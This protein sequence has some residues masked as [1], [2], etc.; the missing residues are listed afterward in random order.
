MKIIIPQ[1]TVFSAMLPKQEY[2]NNGHYRLMQYVVEL[3]YRS[4]TLLFNTLTRELLAL[5]P[6]ESDELRSNSDNALLSTLVEKYFYVSPEFNENQLYQQISIIT[7]SLNNSNVFTHFTVMPTMS[8][9]AR[10]FYCFEHGSKR[11][12]MSDQ[13]SKDVAEFI[14]RRSQG[15]KF[16]ILWFGGEPLYNIKAIDIICDELNKKNLDYTS[17]MISNGYLFDEAVAKRAKNDWKLS[18]VQITLDGTEDIYNKT[19]AYIYKSDKSPFEIVL[20]NIG[21]I[22]KNGIRVLIRL[23]MDSHNKDDLHCLIDLLSKRFGDYKAMISVYVW[24]LYDNR[25]AVKNIKSDME[26][27]ELTEA[28]LGLENSILKAGLSVKSLPDKELKANMC[29]ADGNNCVTV[30]PNGKI[31]KCDHYS[32]SEFIGDIYSN[33]YD[34]KTISRWKERRPEIAICKTCPIRP[35]CIKLSNCPELGSFDCDI[36]EQN[37]LITKLCNQ[38]RN[39]FDKCILQ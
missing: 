37:R 24:L 14:E 11:Y 12:P 22:V 4:N 17:A 9:N 21:T 7:Q 28:L 18:Y 35:Q 34:E 31:G 13:T 15:N 23:N 27:H 3:D 10:C 16:E 25:G 20:N 39:A 32:D 2:K 38:M 30:L 8:C 5:K 6:E 29:S 1:S 36:F 33:V 26:R 19:K